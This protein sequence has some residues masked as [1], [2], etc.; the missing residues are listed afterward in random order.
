MR[1]LKWA[2]VLVVLCTLFV[3]PIASAAPARW[4]ACGYWYQVRWGD[5]LNSIARYTGVS[6]WSISQANGLANPNTIYA[7]QWLWIPCAAPPPPPPSC[8]YWY[9]VRWGDTLNSIAW[10]TGVSA[11]AIAQA[12]GIYNLNRIYAGQALWIPCP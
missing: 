9:T 8:G 5:T 11:W 4:Q 1:Q 3:V 10:R 6:A 2:I 12:N 7:G